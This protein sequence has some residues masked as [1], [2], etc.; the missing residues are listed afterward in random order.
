MAPP[1]GAASYRIIG[2][3]SLGSAPPWCD[4][5]IRGA[6]QHPQEAQ[7]QQWAPPI[8]L[9]RRMAETRST[10]AVLPTAERPNAKLRLDVWPVE[11]AMEAPPRQ[12]GRGLCALEWKS[13]ARGFEACCRAGVIVSKAGRTCPSGTRSGRRLDTR[14]GKDWQGLRWTETPNLV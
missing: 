14:I 10:S 11:T 2:S 6:V 12:P 8:P 3:L 5:A 9:E 13:A 1:R 4:R 7:R